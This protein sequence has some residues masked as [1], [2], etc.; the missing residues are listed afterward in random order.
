MLANILSIIPTLLKAFKYVWLYRQGK[1]VERLQNKAAHLQQ[2]IDKRK[3]H[4]EAIQFA[5]E[6]SPD[7][8]RDLVRIMRKRPKNTN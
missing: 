7:N 2:K 5:D 8:L 4:D 3:A 6:N 1:K